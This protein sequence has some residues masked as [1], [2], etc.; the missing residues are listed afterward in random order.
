MPEGS[1]FPLHHYAPSLHPFSQLNK[2]R[3]CV[4]IL[5][6][7]DFFKISP[8]RRFNFFSNVLFLPH[9]S[10]KSISECQL[11]MADTLQQFSMKSPKKDTEIS[12]FLLITIVVLMEFLSMIS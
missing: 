10:F 2:E 3:T 12:Q 7:W 5:W 9:Y 4:G 6:T 11:P 1:T 8:N